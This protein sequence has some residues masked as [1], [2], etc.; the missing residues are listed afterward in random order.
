[1]VTTGVDVAV[2]LNLGAR[3]R[4][5]P[6]F[7]SVDCDQHQGVDI[8]ADAAD[9]SRFKDG[10]IEEILAS[11]ILE[12]F[13]HHRTSAILKEWARVLKPGGILYIAVPDF[14][15]AVEIYSRYG[16]T[17]WLR[18][19]LYGDQAYQTAFHYTAFDAASLKSALLEAGFSEASRVEDLPIHAEGDCSTLLDT[20]ELRPVSLN[21]VV[22]R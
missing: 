7:L 2:K 5:V 19:W 22:V 6:G 15:R 18:N 1:M 13:P 12:H 20:V 4:A 16:M 17:K 14:E 11:H 3:N 8:V 9:L 21:L 10:Q